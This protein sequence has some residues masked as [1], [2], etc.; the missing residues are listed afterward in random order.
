M[1]NVLLKAFYLADPRVVTCRNTHV[2]LAR[3]LCGAIQSAARAGASQRRR[4]ATGCLSHNRVSPRAK[5]S[6]PLA[7]PAQHSAANVTAT[8]ELSKPF[9][10]LAA[11]RDST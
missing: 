6:A 1:S 7:P 3:D 5:Q 4:H 10:D 2:A 11:C 8:R 9:R